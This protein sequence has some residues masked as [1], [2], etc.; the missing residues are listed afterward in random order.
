M[1]DP[2]LAVGDAIARVTRG[3]SPLEPETVPIGAAAGRV[4]AKDLT[5]SH[6]QPP[7]AASA[8]DGYAVRARDVAEVPARLKVIGEAP[9]GHPFN[10]EVGAGQAVR[11][12]TGS[13]L[14]DGADTIVIQ[15]DTES[16]GDMITVRESAA[17]GR[18]VRPRGFDYSAGEVLLPTG[19]RL[20]SRALALAASMNCADLSV[21]RRPEVAL[22]A[23]GDEL[24]EPGTALEPGQIVSSNNIGL[25][26]FIVRCGGVV[27]DLGIA[28]DTPEDLAAKADLAA[29]ADIL[30]TL[31]GASVGDHDLVQSVL[32]ERGLKVDFWRIAMR[33]GK[34]LI[35][36]RMGEIRLLGLPGNPVSAFVCARIFLK[37]MLDALLGLPDTGDET[38]EAVLGGPLGANDRRQ[39]Y[40]RGRLER[41]PDGKLVAHPF[42]S[43]DSSQLRRLADA[44]CLIIRPPHAPA[45]DAGATVRILPLD[46]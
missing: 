34:P 32:A 15:E 3:L 18:F 8:M 7:F 10:G 11:I 26:S 25:A 1:N 40:M 19:R 22:L 39:E 42:T 46:D 28:R 9:A 36:G 33:P 16:D 4:L 29:G 21:R 45:V 44:D 38:L 31:G 37:P 35:F 14:P 13:A 5:A 30:V 41:G 12:F 24:V 20:D 6:D 27:R 23:T 43:Q 2:L 17:E